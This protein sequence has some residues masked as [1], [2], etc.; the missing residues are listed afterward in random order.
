M[1]LVLSVL[2]QLGFFLLVAGPIAA[3]ILASQASP[4]VSTLARH[5]LVLSWLAYGAA[6]A[7]CLWTC[8]F[9]RSTGVGIGNGIF[10]IIAIPLGFIAGVLF[11]VW[12]A[13]DRDTFV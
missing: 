4:P 12:R 1:S 5:Y 11:S 3:G 6:T 2:L 8:F 7:W 10:L 9:V 13:T